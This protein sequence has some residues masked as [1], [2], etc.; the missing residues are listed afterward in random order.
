MFYNAAHGIKYYLARSLT[1]GSCNMRISFLWQQP[2]Y[3]WPA[4][5]FGAFLLLGALIFGHYGI[6]WDEDLQRQHGTV[7]AQYLNE[8]YPYADKTFNWR[9][10]EEYQYRSYGVCF[11]LPLVWLEEAMGLST[12]RQVYRMRHAATYFVFWLGAVFFYRILQRRF[13][14]WRWALLGSAFLF[15]SPR[16]FGHA[17]FNPKD[18]PFLSLF[19]VST[20]TLYRFWLRP[21]VGNGALHALACGM[22]IGMRITGVLMPAMTVFL[23]VADPLLGKRGTLPP[24]WRRLLGVAAYVPLVIGFTV[25]FW[26][27]LWMDP[28]HQFIAAFAE[29][30]KYGWGGKVVFEGQLLFGTDIPWYYIPKWVGLTTPLLYLLLALAGAVSLLVLLTQHFRSRFYGLWATDRQR[31]DWAALG[32]L[33]APVLAIIVLS[34]VVYD[35][36]RHLY[37]VYPSLLYLSVLGLYGVWKR[38]EARWQKRVLLAALVV[39]SVYIAGWMIANHPHQHIYFNALA[40]RPLLGAYDLDYWGTSYRAALQRLAQLDERPTIKVA[41]GAD[42]PGTQNLAYL[43]PELRKRFVHTPQLEAA[44]YYITNYR[45]WEDQLAQALNRE[46]IYAR[47]EVYVLRVGGAKVLG[48]Y[49][50]KR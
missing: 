37:F 40:P 12:P 25:L 6:S 47:E 30:S 31:M 44:D 5:F 24:V 3:R 38:S 26:P 41:F 27:Y 33:A 45:Y 2:A 39:H 21:N 50:L 14:S 17:F 13:G 42:Y 46:G 36:W 32:L 49:R 34:S 16:L 43:H 29:M 35:G 4:L 7:S 15:L 10:L 11:T 23:F 9:K 1:D 18:I 22:L 19:L 48:I 28:Y 20:W 8:V